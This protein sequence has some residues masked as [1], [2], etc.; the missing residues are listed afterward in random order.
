MLRCVVG[1]LALG[2]FLFTFIMPA[3]SDMANPSDNRSLPMRFQVWQEASSERC[4]DNCR[5]WISA[6]GTITATTPRDFEKFARSHNIR[7]GTLV[8]DSDGGEVLATIT[9]GHAIR[10]L[11]MTTTVGRI[12]EDSGDDDDHLAPLKHLKFGTY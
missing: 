8:L 11:A 6:A 12:V 3:A 5:V 10:K 4:G 9:L 2:S 7:G 1:G